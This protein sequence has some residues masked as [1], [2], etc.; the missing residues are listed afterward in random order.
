[1]KKMI[2]V[3][4]AVTTIV[5]GYTTMV[6]ADSFSQAVPLSLTILEEFGFTLTTYSHDFGTVRT[7][8]G[9]E[10]TIGIFC[11][12]NHGLAWNLALN[13]DEFSNGVTT[14]PEGD[15][16]VYAAWGDT[17]GDFVY[18]G[19]FPGAP[20]DPAPPVPSTPTVFYNSSVA[21]NLYI[22]DDNSALARG[23]VIDTFSESTGTLIEFEANNIY[24][25]D[26]GYKF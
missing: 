16:F 4:L 25:L 10:T 13:A 8:E 11:F 14:I 26:I 6:K 17:A 12:S 23:N 2:V 24:I 7:G 9:A 1:M 20:F 15:A 19:T 5:L 22:I 18:E 3:L 21:D